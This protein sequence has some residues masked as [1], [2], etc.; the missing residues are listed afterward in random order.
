MQNE[1]QKRIVIVG[2][3][4]AGVN[5][6]TKI[7]KDSNYKIT[8]VD[9][10]NYNFFPPLIYQVATG[11]LETSSI[12][13]PFRKLFRNHPGFQFRLGE[14]IK[15]DPSEHICYLNNGQVHYDYLVF[16][17]GSATNYFGN[18]NIKNNAIPMKTVNDALHMRNMLL[19]N[20]EQACQETDITIRK[21]L[22]TIVVAGGGPTGVEVAGMLAE[23]RKYILTKDYPELENESG[24][25][26]LINGASRLLEQ[27]S[28]QS[29]WE[30]YNA[31]VKLGVEVKLDNLVKDF[32]NDQV[33]LANGEIIEAK[34]LIWAAGIIAKTFQGVPIASIGKGKRMITDEYNRVNGLDD[35]Y[36]IGDICI[37]KNDPA[38]PNGHPQLAQPAIQ[39]GINLANNFVRMRKAAKLIPFIYTDKGNM[40]IIGR[41]KA[42]CD[43]FKSKLHIGGFI[44]LMMWLF[45]HLMSLINYRNKLRTLFNWTAA[46]LSKDQSLRMIIRPEGNTQKEQR[47]LQDYN[48]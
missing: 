43:L 21:K 40:A 24:Q 48:F 18:D 13:Y 11:F 16:A 2:G 38:Y 25:I 30:A 39:Q 9:K 45:V 34:N 10:N 27:M 14:L 28:E 29:H 8:L 5:L 7:A 23:L 31:L 4:F 15:I 46:Y 6:A 26:Y 42:V 41:N 3:G 47:A 35:V 22:L 36:A 1:H 17:C 37:Q 20:L 32:Y 19:Q 44:A 33:V 12:S